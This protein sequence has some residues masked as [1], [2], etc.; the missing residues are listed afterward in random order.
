MRNIYIV[1]SQTYTILARIIKFS[2]KEKYSHVSISLNKNCTEMYSFGRKYYWNPFIARF[3]CESINKG[4]Y[5]KRKKC[6]IKIYSVKVSNEQFEYLKDLINEFKKNESIYRYN[7]LGLF[8]TKMGIKKERKNKFYC[9]E[10]VY[11]VLSN[12]KV[13][14]IDKIDKPIEL[15][16]VI[17]EE[18]YNLLYEGK[19]NNYC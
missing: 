15:R 10:F 8:Y 14:I 2:T 17:N 6:L 5:K 4:L 3:V 16:D 11:N 9:A 12:D 13:K 18:T 19:V 7:L 1:Y